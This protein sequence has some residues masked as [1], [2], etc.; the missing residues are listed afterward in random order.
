[1]RPLGVTAALLR[2]AFAEG[3]SEVLDFF[4]HHA[5][6]FLAT[7][8][9][10]VSRADIGSRR[11]RRDMRGH[12]NEHAR[13]PGSGAARRDVNHHRHLGTEHF[14]NDRARGIEQASRRV[15]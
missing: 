1:M 12:R 7:A 11:H 2:D 8:G 14:L 15:H 5:F 13:R 10:R 4:T 6:D 9:D 3:G